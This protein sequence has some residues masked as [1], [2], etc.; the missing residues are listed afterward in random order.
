MMST[1]EHFGIE[2]LNQSD[3]AFYSFV[4]ASV[5][6]V[7]AKPFSYDRRDAS[8]QFRA[9]ISG[10]EVVKDWLVENLS[11]QG[12]NQTRALLGQEYFYTLRSMFAYAIVNEPA[13]QF[14]EH[15]FV[16][17]IFEV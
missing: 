16:R 1:E 17:T 8:C 5:F 2:S 11:L 6:A 3:L 7:S 13:K 15:L 12:V 14:A 10:L 4:V 9:S